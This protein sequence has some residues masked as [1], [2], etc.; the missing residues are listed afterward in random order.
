[1]DW[2]DCDDEM[3]LETLIGGLVMEEGPRNDSEWN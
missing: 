3:T 2:C 1:M